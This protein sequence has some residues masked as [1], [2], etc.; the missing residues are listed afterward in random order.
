MIRLCLFY[1]DDLAEKMYDFK[2]PGVFSFMAPLDSMIWFCVILAYVGVS[3]V[4]F[5][6]SRFSPYEWHYDPEKNDHALN[7]DFTI[8]N[9]LWFNLAAVMQQGVDIAPK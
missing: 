1:F 8:L 7:N 2:K 9:T 6:V 3:I 4:L 5:L